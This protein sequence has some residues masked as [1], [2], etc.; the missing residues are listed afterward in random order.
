MEMFGDW[1][2]TWEKRRQIDVRFYVPKKKVY[3]VLV[4]V[5]LLLLLLLLL[6]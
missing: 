1:E 2:C 4:C 3:S 6:L 5:R